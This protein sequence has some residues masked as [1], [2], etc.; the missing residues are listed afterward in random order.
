MQAVLKI[1]PT[2]ALEENIFFKLILS[3]F[4]ASFFLKLPSVKSFPNYRKTYDSA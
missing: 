4:I 2:I 1:V 3:T